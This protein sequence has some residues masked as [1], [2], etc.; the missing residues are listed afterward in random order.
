MNIEHSYLVI[1]PHISEFPEPLFLKR[2]DRVSVGE[3]YDGP[4]GW[5]DWYLCFAPGLEPGFVPGQILE[6][7]AD[8]TATL[9]EDFTNKELDVVPGEILYGGRQQNGWVWAT[10]QSDGAAGWVPLQNVR[11][12]T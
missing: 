8:G 9:R 1:E 7:H 6:R 10:R 3:V 12:C 2:G 5:P 4:E 11:S